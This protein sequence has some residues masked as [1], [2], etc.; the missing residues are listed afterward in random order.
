MNYPKDNIKL[1]I[2]FDNF[3]NTTLITQLARWPAQIAG[4]AS[5]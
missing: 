2:L 3:D 4:V 1:H 5:H